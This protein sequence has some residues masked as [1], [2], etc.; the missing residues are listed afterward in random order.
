MDAIIETLISYG[1][2]AIWLVILVVSLFLEGITAGL[3]TIWFAGGAL[4]A[5]L[6]SLLGAPIW[7]QITMFTL[8]SVVLLFAARPLMSQWLKKNQT[9]TNLDSVIG[10]EAKVV[11]D[12][13]NIEQTGAVTLQGKTWTARNIDDK[14]NT[15]KA[16]CIVKVVS[17]QG[18]KLLIEYKKDTEE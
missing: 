2:T 18:V 6:F 14:A 15:V 5:L 16:G 1:S 12:I 17:I 7:L 10:A 9:P 8:I 4:I 13:N 11:E 3:V